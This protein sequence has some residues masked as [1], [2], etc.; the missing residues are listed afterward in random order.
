MIWEEDGCP[1]RTIFLGIT[2][3]IKW[4]RL[5]SPI[6]KFTVCSLCHIV[7]F[8]VSDMHACSIS[9]YFKSLF[10]ACLLKRFTGWV[11]IFLKLFLCSRLSI[12]KKWKYF[13]WWGLLPFHACLKWPVEFSL[14]DGKEREREKIRASRRKFS[15]RISFLLVFS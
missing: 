3:N 15:P 12:K 1:K 11:W 5:F 8:S 10:S 4:S 7:R 14:T 13:S 9:C 6:N 2:Q